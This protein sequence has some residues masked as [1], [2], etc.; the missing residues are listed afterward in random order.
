MQPMESGSMTISLLWRRLTTRRRRYGSFYDT[1]DV[2]RR[3]IASEARE[4]AEPERD[5]EREEDRA[6]S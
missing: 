5:V 6:A 1:Q 2:M 3:A 4:K